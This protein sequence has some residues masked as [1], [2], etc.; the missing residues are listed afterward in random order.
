[1][2]SSVRLSSVS[3]QGSASLMR[4]THPVEIFGNVS[5]PFGTSASVDIHGKFYGD[6][7]RE[8]TPSGEGLN[9]RRVAKY[10]DVEPIKDCLENGAR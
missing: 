4:R 5:T 9:A 10:S 8:T 7:P 1:M 6:R 3:R 2:L